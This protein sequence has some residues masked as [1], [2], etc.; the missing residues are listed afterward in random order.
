MSATNTPNRGGSR[1]QV[2]AADRV[3]EQNRQI[4]SSMLGD[5]NKVIGEKVGN[6]KVD[7][8]TERVVLENLPSGHWIERHNTVAQKIAAVCTY[9]GIPVEREPFGLFRHLVPQQALNILHQN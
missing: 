9:A 4:I 1:H 5:V 6:S 8:H 7:K 2:Q 3:R